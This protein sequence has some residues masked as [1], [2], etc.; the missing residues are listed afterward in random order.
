MASSVS[1]TISRF[2]YAI[3]HPTGGRAYGSSTAVT[4]EELVVLAR[5]GDTG[6]FDQ[7]VIRHQAAVYRAAV[8]ALRNAEDAE[9]AAQDAFVRAWAGLHR[10]RGEA[11]FRTWL[12]TIVWN[13]ALTRRRGVVAW[14]RRKVPLDEAAALPMAAR[15]PEDDA[16]ASEV[17]SH[18]ARA[19]ESLTPK[20][21]DTLLL[22]QSGE[23][24]YEE[25]AAMLRIPVGTVKWRVSD[26]RRRVRAQLAGLGYVDAR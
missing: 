13:G 26:A 20:L 21:R 8:A 3:D 4:D 23:Y 6:A 14:F 22:A 17:K 25:I 16:R 9:E 5:A 7:L 19:I 18:A 11:S 2:S 24:E 15:S 12:L 1:M 10:F